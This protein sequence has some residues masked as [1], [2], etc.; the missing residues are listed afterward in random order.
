MDIERWE[1][2]SERELLNKYHQ[3]SLSLIFFYFFEFL[4]D[5]AVNCKKEIDCMKLIIMNKVYI[6]IIQKS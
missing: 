5:S 4:L 3:T 6:K 2:K 1:M